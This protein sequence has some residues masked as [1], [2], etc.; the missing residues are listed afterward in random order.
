M[1][2]LIEELARAIM[3]QSCESDEECEELWNDVDVCRYNAIV[4]ARAT[5]PVF[6]KWL[7][8]EADMSS[9]VAVTNKCGLLRNLAAHLE[10]E[11]RS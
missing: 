6:A 7:R 11:S 1:S 10:A 9:P 3:R 5:I 8:L 2:K 4:D